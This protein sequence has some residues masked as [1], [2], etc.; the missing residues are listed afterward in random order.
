MSNISLAEKIETI[1]LS[2]LQRGTA[3]GKFGAIVRTGSSYLVKAEGRP[4]QVWLENGGW[5]VS[6]AGGIVGADRSLLE[7]AHLCV[8]A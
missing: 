2:Y 6:K 3:V 8:T 7:A 5:C 1:V 4:F